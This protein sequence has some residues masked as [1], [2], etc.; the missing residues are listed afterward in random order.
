VRDLET[1]PDVPDPL[2]ARSRREAVLR[3]TPDRAGSFTFLCDVFCG[4]GHENMSGTLNVS[5]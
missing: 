5:G 1:A 3:F 2:R 4:S